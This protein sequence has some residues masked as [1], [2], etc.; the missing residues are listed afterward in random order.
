[1]A[2]PQLCGV[3]IDFGQSK[4]GT[5]TPGEI[6]T[7]QFQGTVGQVLNISIVGTSGAGWT[8]YDPTGTPVPRDGERV[9]LQRSGT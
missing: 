2:Q 4:P 3:P 6:D 9:T 1:M 5:F 8:L 7:Y